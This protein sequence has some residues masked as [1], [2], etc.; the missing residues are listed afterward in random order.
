MVRNFPI[1][2]ILVLL[3]L[4]VLGCGTK[5]KLPQ[6]ILAENK[7]KSVL[8]DMMKADLFLADFVLNK[9]TAKRKETESIK[10]YDTIFAIHQITPDV[11]FKSLSYYEQHPALLKPILDSLGL[12]HNNLRNK[13]KPQ[14]E[15]IPLPPKVEQ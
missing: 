15:T 5:D 13:I 8:D 6:G 10:R 3:F 11:F 9:D 2:I 14:I 4:F 7:M 12:Q 1:N